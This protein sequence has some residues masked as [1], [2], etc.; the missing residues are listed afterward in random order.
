MFFFRVVWGDP[1]SNSA[2]KSN[3]PLHLRPILASLAGVTILKKSSSSISFK[4]HAFVFSFQEYCSGR[5]CKPWLPTKNQ[6]LVVEV[7]RQPQHW[8]VE[9]QKQPGIEKQ[10]QHGGVKKQKQPGIQKQ[11]QRGGV[12]KKPGI[13]KHWCDGKTQSCEW[14]QSSFASFPV[15]TDHPLLNTPDHLW[16]LQVKEFVVAFDAVNPIVNLLQIPPFSIPNCCVRCDNYVRIKILI[17]RRVS[18]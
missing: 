13:E 6:G 17:F 12:D 9:K 10:R 8:R 18:L 3:L 14:F 4:S 15:P 7:Q 5:I 11:R 1:R 2:R 16:P